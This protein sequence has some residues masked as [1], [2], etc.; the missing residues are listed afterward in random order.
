MSAANS[1]ERIQG[2]EGDVMNGDEFGVILDGIWLL[3]MMVTR[4]RGNVPLP[5]GGFRRRIRRMSI[6]TANY[7]V[8]PDWLW[9]RMDRMQKK[10]NKFLSMQVK[11]SDN[12]D[13][14]D[15]EDMK[16]V[17]PEDQWDIMLEGKKPEPVGTHF[18]IET[19]KAC[20]DWELN[21]IA[22]YNLLHKATPTPGW[23]VD[24]LPTIGCVHWEQPPDNHRSYMLVGDP[25]QGNPPHR[26]AGVV[27]VFDVTEFPQK[28]ALLVFFKW[29]FGN[30]SYDPWKIAFK[31]AYDVYRPT[32]SLVENTGTQKLWTEQ[33]F[34]DLGMWVEGSDFSGLKKGMLVATVRQMQ[35]AKY[36]FPYINGL[37][38][39]L[40]SYDIAKDT[41]GNKLPQDIV[42][43]FFIASWALRDE[44]HASMGESDHQQPAAG[45]PVLE[46]SREARS[47]ILIPRSEQIPALTQRNGQNGVALGRFPREVA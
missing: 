39:Q 9:N 14:E 18:S 43:I 5:F 30:M 8:A 7:A 4:M 45:P 3:I 16:E 24:E 15:I 20:E 1:A 47:Q 11:S 27:A 22:E 35:R 12:L 44:L 28:A 37:R 33:I 41:E 40:V 25:G 17:I 26:N 34:F 19:I 10:P 42:T 31:Y 36:R 46:S 2:W 6:I 13:P 23:R 38:S 29:V 21:H 32:R